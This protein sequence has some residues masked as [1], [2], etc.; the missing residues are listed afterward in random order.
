MNGR[1]SPGASDQLNLWQ[2]D[3]GYNKGN[4]DAR[5]EFA[6]MYQQ[7]TSYIGNN[8]RRTGL[9][10]QVAYIPRDCGIRYLQN[11]EFV[12]RY[13][14]ERFRGIDPTQLDFTAF[15]DPTDAPVDRDQYTLGFNYYLYPSM[16]LRFA[17]EINHELHGVN[18]HDNVFRAQFVWGF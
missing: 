11:L 17:Y 8:I 3:L 9:Y 13:S 10:A 18:L 12:F 7:A 2:I 5:F 15:A 4:W 14:M 6:Q 16:A 1:Y